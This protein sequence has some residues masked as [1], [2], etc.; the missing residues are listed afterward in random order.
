[1]LHDVRPHPDVAEHVE[2]GEEDRDERRNPAAAQQQG[3][4]RANHYIAFLLK[5]QGQHKASVPY[6]KR[7][8]QRNN[9]YCA[10]ELGKIYLEG[11]GEVKADAKL[12]IEFL[13]QSA[14]I[15]YAPAQ[16][17]LAECYAGSYPI[18][19]KDYTKM[20]DWLWQAST[21]SP[22]AMTKIGYCYMNGIELK[23]D[24]YLA[25]KWFRKAAENGEFAKCLQNG[26]G[27]DKD[28][29]RASR[30][31]QQAVDIAEGRKD[32]MLAGAYFHLALSHILG[33]GGEAD[34]HKGFMLFL[35]AHESNPTYLPA[36]M[37]I[38]TFYKTGRAYAKD[39][40]K[41]SP[42]P[43]KS[44]EYFLK[45][46][47]LKNPQAQ[48]EVADAYYYGK[49]VE[50]NQEKARQ[51]FKLAADQGHPEAAAALKKLF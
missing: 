8:A 7:A 42:D 37:N 31:Y 18:I 38:A 21:K 35:K 48:L 14:Q 36:I 23:K 24:P 2:A 51:Y 11:R 33:V 25:V 32:K 30:V 27:I 1:M 12:A 29:A 16:L 22:E 13:T 47:E 10:F 17:Q 45:A 5:S 40:K 20:V 50:K 19:E 43:K 46:A 44:F 41:L 34:D 6:F 4:Y 26:I 3:I 28:E 9:K 49:G 39:G 15:G